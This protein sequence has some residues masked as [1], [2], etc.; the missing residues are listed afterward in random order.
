[1]DAGI[2]QATRTAP[3]LPLPVSW[4]GRN[5]MPIA[6]PDWAVIAQLST[7]QLRN[8]LAQIGY[9]SS[10]WNYAKIGTANQLGRYQF[11]TSTLES[12]GLLTTGATAVYGTD[13][14]NYQHCWRAPVSTYADYMVEIA[15]L[16]EFLNNATA[17]EFLAYQRV[18]D[19]YSGCI[20]IGAI[21]TM[22]SADTVAGML[23]VAWELGV[24]TPSTLNNS[25]GTGAYAWRYFNVGAGAAYYATGRYAVEVLSK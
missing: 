10:E 23:Y 12:Y 19:L 22:D 17:Q 1:M 14:V 9:V 5:D 4:S 7:V 13:A 18:Q 3:V 16:T 6:C 15:S 8:L 21:K 24:G 25:S 2:Q 20:K 11:S